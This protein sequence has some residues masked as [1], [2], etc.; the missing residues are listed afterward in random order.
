MF[1][2]Q[3]DCYHLEDIDEGEEYCRLKQ[4][5]EMVGFSGVTQ[6]RCGNISLINCIHRLAICAAD[7]EKVMLFLLEHSHLLWLLFKLA[8]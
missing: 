6:A 3:S 2:S 7:W 1:I 8:E 5:M 4:S